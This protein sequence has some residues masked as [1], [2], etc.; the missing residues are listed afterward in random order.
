MPRR[1]RKHSQWTCQGIVSCFGS[2]PDVSRGLG[3]RRHKRI[4][5]QPF[6]IYRKA[7]ARAI[8]P[9]Q[10]ARTSAMTPAQPARHT[11]GRFRAAQLEFG[12]SRQAGF[13]KRSR[14]H[15][16]LQ[17]NGDDWSSSSSSPTWK[18]SAAEVPADHV[19]LSRSCPSFLV[20]RGKE[21]PSKKDM[22]APPRM[23]IQLSN[24]GSDSLTV[25]NPLRHRNEGEGSDDSLTTIPPSR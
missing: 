2:A 25:L 9:T 16:P 13:S 17:K 12:P 22:A 6:C 18:K 11:F 20:D 15:S 21:L 19:Q 1:R 8:V 5:A 14:R 23:G 4:R 7:L 10:H 3:C 24:T